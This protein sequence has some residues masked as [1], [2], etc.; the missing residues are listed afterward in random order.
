[1]TSRFL[2]AALVTVCL[3]AVLAPP[4]LSKDL[5]NIQ[6][7]QPPPWPLE[8]LNS[9]ERKARLKFVL[10][11][12][13]YKVAKAQEPLAESDCQQL[14]HQLKKSEAWEVL[15]PDRVVQ[16]RTDSNV[17]DNLIE[18]CSAIEIDRVWYSWEKGPLSKGV[19]PTFD[20]LSLDKKDEKADYYLKKTG[21]IEFYDVSRFFGGKKTWATFAEGGETVCNVDSYKEF[22]PLCSALEGYR[23][24][25][26]VVVG[27]V[28]DSESCA[29]H[30]PSKVKAG[31]RLRVGTKNPYAF[32][33]T[34]NFYALM[35][36][37]GVLY[38]V[39]LSG[40]PAWGNFHSLLTEGLTTLV[41]EPA[42]RKTGGICVYETDKDEGK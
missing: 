42:A 20:E 21:P 30:L 41:A 28:V 31:G 2:F 39:G 32:R 25:S 27:P 29:V 9:Q 23:L 4:S 17:P 15:D 1:M 24:M 16:S 40:A 18:H 13:N 38:R 33:E 12:Q 7:L 8:P 26:D 19:D 22:G 36:I 34:A 11:T 37:D 6:S 5:A 14:L 35:D 3:S 10:E